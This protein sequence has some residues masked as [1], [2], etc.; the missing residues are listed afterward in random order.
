[1]QK[2]ATPSSSTSKVPE[3]LFSSERSG[4]KRA[5]SWPMP[6]SRFAACLGGLFGPVDGFS[7]LGVE[8]SLEDQHNQPA[9]ARLAEKVATSAHL[10][11]DGPETD[12]GAGMVVLL[13]VL[14]M[15]VDT[16]G[17]AVET[18]VVDVAAAAEGTAV[19][20]ADSGF[21]IV[22]IVDS[23]LG[24]VGIVDSGLGVVGTAV[25]ATV[26]A[27]TAAVEAAAAGTA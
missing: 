10:L 23:E 4:V 5:A 17:V 15:P 21:G 27:D 14:P 6:I 8:F 2:P 1:M 24:V 19:G 7:G 12:A 13:L 11:E 16:V 25:A 3:N 26:A 20:T 18:A 22:C 9:Y